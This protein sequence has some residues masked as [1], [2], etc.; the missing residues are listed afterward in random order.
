ME[1]ILKN[2]P[3]RVAKAVSLYWASTGICVD[4]GE[5]SPLRGEGRERVFDE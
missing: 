3:E 1:S 5:P 2:L 4:K